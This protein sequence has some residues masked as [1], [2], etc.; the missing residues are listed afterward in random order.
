MSVISKDNTGEFY[1]HGK[2]YAVS[3]TNCHVN[4]VLDVVG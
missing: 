3:A 1:G 4:S 2:L